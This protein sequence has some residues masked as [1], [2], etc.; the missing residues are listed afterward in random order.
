[1]DTHP[2]DH[3]EEGMGFRKNKLPS[4]TFNT[5]PHM[6]VLRGRGRKRE[7]ER[8]EKKK[9]QDEDARQGRILTTGFIVVVQGFH[10]QSVGPLRRRRETHGALEKSRIFGK[11]HYSMIDDVLTTTEQLTA[12]CL[13]ETKL[14]CT[15]LPYRKQSIRANVK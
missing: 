5:A 15:K 13:L 9:R 2:V 4:L 12:F 3:V 1:M 14:T 6:A 10:Y 8:G 7:R 11:T